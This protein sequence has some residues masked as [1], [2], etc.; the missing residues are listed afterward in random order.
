MIRCQSVIENMK[1]NHGKAVNS[2]VSCK[3]GSYD[4]DYEKY[5]RHYCLM[6]I[7]EMLQNV[8]HRIYYDFC[9]NG[10]WLMIMYNQLK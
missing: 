7:G 8:A 10:S 4:I 2:L 9:V 1:K 5:K 6:R 3:D